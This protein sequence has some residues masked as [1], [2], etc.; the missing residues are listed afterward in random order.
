MN[1]TLN[2][3]LNENHVGNL[4]LDNKYYCFQ[5][6]TQD[7]PPIS[8]SLPVRVESYTNDIPKPYFA[9]LLPEGETRTAIEGKLGI[10]RG[11][12]FELLNK[13]GGDCAGAITLFPEDQTPFVNC[14]YIPLSN[15]ELV[16][17]IKELPQNPLC[18]GM[19]KVVRLSLPGAQNKTALYRK[20]GIYHVPENG[21]PSS[22]ILKT[23]ITNIS[24]IV[25]TVQNETFV[26][27]L[28]KE[29][30]LNVP[31]VEL[32]TVGGIPVFVTGRYDR[33]IDKDNT[34]RRVLQEDFCQL[35]GFEPSVKYQ[36]QG[37]PG[38]E[39]C[40]N[41]LRKH[42][43]NTT[44]DIEQFLKWISFNVLVGNSDAHAKNI[45]MIWDVNTG[46]KLAPF[47]D[48]L[49]TTVYGENHDSDFAMSIG[50]EY[51]P[52]NI[53]RRNWKELSEHLGVHIKLINKINSKMLESIGKAK[54]ITFDIFE[55]KYGS[56]PT[57]IKICA[58]IDDR[59]KIIE[60]SL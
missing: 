18:V 28:A 50:R 1:P 37:G 21:A 35:L 23:P 12:D 15:D 52:E 56:N 8:L 60:R 3:Y 58:H 11:D 6:I 39:D 54:K 4:W 32:I 17:L 49:S 26:M 42:S 25:G 40:I 53:T 10:I 13:I 27:M 38:L 29:V 24:G 5:Y 43:C 14:R 34:M 22:H 41:I 44:H 45:S 47:Y 2:V 30:G 33:C 59:A 55:R 9:N 51:H 16:T 19:S 7:T 48:L 57:V 46:I 20:D 31:S 36:N